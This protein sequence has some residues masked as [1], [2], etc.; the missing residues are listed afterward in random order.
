MSAWRARRWV[1]IAVTL[2]A[3]AALQWLRA[4]RAEPATT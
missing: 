2:A 1:A 3:L 4:A